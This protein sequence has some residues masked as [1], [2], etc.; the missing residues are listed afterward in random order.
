MTRIVVLLAL[1]ALVGC[2]NRT[3]NDA[4]YWGKVSKEIGRRI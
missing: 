4:A 2:A 1:M 3:D